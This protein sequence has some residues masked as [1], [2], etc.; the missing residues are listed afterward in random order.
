[1]EENSKKVESPQSPRLKIKINQNK[2]TFS[3]VNHMRGFFFQLL[4]NV[5]L[6]RLDKIRRVQIENRVSTSLA[7]CV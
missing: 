4:K 5:K 6:I 2:F 3:L 1:M 7:S